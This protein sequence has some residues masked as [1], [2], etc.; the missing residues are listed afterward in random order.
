MP[1]ELRILEKIHCP[2]CNGIAEYRIDHGKKD[3]NFVTVYIVCPVCRLNRYSHTATFK[4][5][6]L[7]RKIEKLEK[8]AEEKPHL[9][10]RIQT[11]IKLLKQGN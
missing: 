2:R 11:A 4:E 10:G 6:K 5:I 8:R 7:T 1:F 3:K 9:R